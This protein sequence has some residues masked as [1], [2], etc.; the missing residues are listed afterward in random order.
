[1]MSPTAPLHNTSITSFDVKSD[2]SLVLARFNDDTHLDPD[3]VDVPD[4]LR[5]A[6][7]LRLIRHGQSTGNPTGVWEGS[8]GEGL[9]AVGMA[10]AARLAEALDVS[11]V[12]SSDAPRARATA[13]SLAPQVS[14]E[15]GL[16]ELDPG[17]WEGLTFDELVAADPSL[18]ARIY[19]HREDLPRGGDGETWEALAQRMRSTVDGI[20][21][22]SDGDVTVVSHGSAI[23]AY[24]L[25]LMG[26]GWEEQPRLAT[27]PNTGLAEVLV[28]DGTTRLNAYGLAP[29]LGDAVAPGR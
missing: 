23:R 21:G 11:A 19:R 10:Q 5:D 27:M 29:W 15:P 25:D 6:R 24:L 26:L 4:F 8:G 12:F 18:A 7:R 28:L 2:G 9:T 16:R 13:E 17:S 14:V 3:H 20:V 1:P 22:R